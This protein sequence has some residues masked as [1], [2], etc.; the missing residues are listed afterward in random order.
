[1]NEKI[2]EVVNYLKQLPSPWKHIISAILGA[3]VALLLVS[4]CGT[5]VFMRTTNDGQIT[6]TNTP[7][8]TTT[9][10]ANLTSQ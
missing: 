6:I 7:S 4:S 5:S 3:I 9:V 1:M 8:T 10:D 2:T